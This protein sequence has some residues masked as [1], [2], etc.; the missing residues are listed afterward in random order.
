[1]QFV[2]RA[3]CGGNWYATLLGGA[4]TPCAAVYI[5]EFCARRSSLTDLE[6]EEREGTDSVL[7]ATYTCQ[8]TTEEGTACFSFRGIIRDDG[9]PDEGVTKEMILK[10]LKESVQPD[11]PKS[12]VSPF[13]SVLLNLTFWV[14]QLKK[15]PDL[16]KILV[17]IN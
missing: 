7:T 14:S 15:Y 8:E 6:M 5:K 17:V 9:P 13:V 1:M 16:I 12:C 3:A 4:R 2:L 10:L 11:I